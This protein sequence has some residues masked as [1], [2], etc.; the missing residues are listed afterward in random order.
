MYPHNVLLNFWTELGLLGLLLFIWIIFRYFYIAKQAF[1]KARAAHD[2]FAWIIF[3]LSMAM[4][5]MIIHGI[6]DVPYFK[7]DLALLFWLMMALMGV[8]KILIT[9]EH[10]NR[11]L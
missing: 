4:L 11:H 9:T 8:G 6:V 5:A 2:S 3:G 10:E 1:N 7:N